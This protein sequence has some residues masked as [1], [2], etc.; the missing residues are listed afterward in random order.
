LY[1]IHDALP[2]AKTSQGN[3]RFEFSSHA[4]VSQS[5]PSQLAKLVFKAQSGTWA[6]LV[7]PLTPFQT[8]RMM[9]C[10]IRACLLP[11]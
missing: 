3:Y 7:E 9:E 4:F 1:R 5:A 2:S 8:M 6:C 11:S 10:V